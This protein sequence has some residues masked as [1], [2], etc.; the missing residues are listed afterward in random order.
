MRTNQ[1]YLERIKDR[2][3]SNISWVE[4]RYN[5]DLIELLLD[6]RTLLGDIK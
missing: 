2:N 4:A 1:H 6:I 5:Q 3:K